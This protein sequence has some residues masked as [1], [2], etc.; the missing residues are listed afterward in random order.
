[1]AINQ[2]DISPEDQ[3]A[4][5][6]ILPDLQIDGRPLPSIEGLN[7]DNKLVGCIT[8]GEN[9][10]LSTQSESVETAL[11]GSTPTSRKQQPH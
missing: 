6:G 3:R 1:M 7:D 9:K 2:S 8:L 11:E 4:V 10:T 5:N